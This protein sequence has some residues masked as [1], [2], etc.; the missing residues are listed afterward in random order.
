MAPVKKQKKPK[1]VTIEGKELP[2]KKIM[3][4]QK[5]FNSV[6]LS[7]SRFPPLA[8]PG[9]ELGR[10]SPGLSKYNPILVEQRGV[11]LETGPTIDAGRLGE[12][13]EEEDVVNFGD[14]NRQ[15]Q[16]SVEGV[17]A[18]RTAGDARKNSQ[19]SINSSLLSKISIRVQ[20]SLRRKFKRK[21]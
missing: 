10:V 20:K 2:S 16:K 14:T 21:N 4:N 8:P 18:E 15:S 3:R 5:Q 12:M 1:K 13:N 11:T 19:S 17:E 7:H 6:G 9:Q